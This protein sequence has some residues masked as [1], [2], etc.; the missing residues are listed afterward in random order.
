MRTGRTAFQLASLACLLLIAGDSAAQTAPGDGPRPPLAAPAPAVAGAIAELRKRDPDASLTYAGSHV[1]SFATTPKTQ[2]PDYARPILA[3]LGLPL[4]ARPVRS[5]LSPSRRPNKGED[6]ERG[7]R[8]L[9]FVSETAAMSVP[10]S[11]ATDVAERG[12]KPVPLDVRR[13]R[14]QHPDQMVDWDRPDPRTAALEQ[15]AA[16]PILSAFLSSHARL[17]DIDPAALEKSVRAPRFHSSAQVR[18]L[19]F[20][21]Y[22]DGEKVLYG[23]TVVQF[24]PN[25]NVTAVSRML[26]TP[27][28]LKLQTDS[29]PANGGIGEALAVRGALASPAARE[30]VG[31]E[32][33]AVR[34]ERALDIVRGVRVFDIESRSPDGDCHW[35]TIVDAATGRVLNVTDLVDRAFTDARV[36]RWRYPGGNLMTPEQVVSTNQYTRNDRRLEHD[37][38]YLMNDHRCEGAGETACGETSHASTWC[39]AAYGS[40]SGASFIRATRRTDRDFSP[41]FPGGASETFA[42]T[43][44]YY[45]ARQFSQWIKPSLDAMGVLPGSASD[46]PRVLLIADACR[47]GSVHNASFSVSTD[48]DKGEGT[49]VIRLAHRNPAGAS[50]HNASC[51]GGGCFDNPS[52]LHHE[53]N[54][55]FLRR[56]YE[57]GSDLDCGGANQM[58][59]IHE[60]ALGTAVPQAFWHRHHGVGYAPSSTDQLYFSHSDIGKVHTNDATRMTVSANLCTNSTADSGPYVAGRVVGQA[61]WKFYHGV[62]VDGSTQSGTWRPTTDTD[63]NWITYWAAEL[64]AASTY[65]D[66]YEYANRFMEI[67]DKHTN[68]SSSGKK[69]Y[70]EI[71]QAHGLRTYINPDYCE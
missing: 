39:S 2:I 57:F 11:G 36:N 42:E 62:K 20:D 56:Y 67:L 3:R 54:H 49:N 8:A 31:K 55:F 21:Q 50:N 24:D 5:L 7:G 28:K 59:F 33:R 13:K 68:W 9:P 45:W 40:T 30:C 63:F 60:G 12:G 34:T 41:Y 65:K 26:L 64:M 53:L 17:F 22:V 10:S 14:A 71:F 43:H 38:F 66:R 15:R 23:R 25:W 52:N 46:Y 29:A 51:E 4:K 48:D 47:S 19:S 18:K 16:L 35:R 32:A 6:L 37:F 61:L 27:A 1:D 70:C 58:K 69:D 44:A